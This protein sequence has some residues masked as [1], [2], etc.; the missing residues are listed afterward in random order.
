MNESSPTLPAWRIAL[1]QAFQDSWQMIDPLRP[2]PAGTYARGEH[3]GI[4]SALK[5]VRDNFERRIAA[6]EA[7]LLADPAGAGSELPIDVYLDAERYRS[8]NTPEIGDF[9]RG[10][11]N[12]ALHQRQRWGSNQDQGKSDNDWFWLIN[13]L[14]GKAAQAETPDKRLHHIITTAAACLN[15]HAA[16]LGAYA[17]ALDDSA[18]AEEANSAAATQTGGDRKPND[19]T[20]AD[21]E[22]HRCIAEQGLQQDGF[23]LN[24]VKMILCPQCGD[25]RC[26]KA[27]DHRVQCNGRPQ[28]ER[29]QTAQPPE[30]FAVTQYARAS[31]H[32]ETIDRVTKRDGSATW[33]VR[34]LGC[35][36]NKD[37]TWEFE[38]SP[39]LRDDVFLQRCRFASA[40]EAFEAL[41]ASN[42]NQQSLD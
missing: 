5:T 34:S 19:A 42:A 13:H 37:G 7:A 39:S 1:E 32:R 3:N 40:E 18:L 11:R 28:D 22:C 23:P 6:I 25:K 38:P 12:E 41:K 36:L 30:G 15:W 2:P 33:A 24:A 26:P 10:V 8:I 35:C 31:G 4:A 29:A 21:C 27:S 17:P 16:R 9:L 20:A 14:A